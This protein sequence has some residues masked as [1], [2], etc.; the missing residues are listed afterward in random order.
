MGEISTPDIQMYSDAT[1]FD[2]NIQLKAE[3]W[4]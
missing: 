4:M 2:I 1:Y 3:S